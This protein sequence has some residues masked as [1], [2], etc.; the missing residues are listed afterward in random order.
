MAYRITYGPK[1]RGEKQRP[2]RRFWIFA[3]AVVLV[4]IL[5]A[6]GTGETLKNWLLPG[7]AAVTEQALQTFA[8]QLEEGESLGDA[9]ACFCREIIENA[10]T[11]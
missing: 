8:Q 5:Y 11:D 7:D 9:F 2:K 10:Q 3:A 6:A 1:V 4:L